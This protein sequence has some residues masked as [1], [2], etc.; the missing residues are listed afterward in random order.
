LRNRVDNQILLEKLSNILFLEF[1]MMIRRYID[2]LEGCWWAIGR[3]LQGS[4]ST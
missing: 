3:D 1:I 2:G 4:S